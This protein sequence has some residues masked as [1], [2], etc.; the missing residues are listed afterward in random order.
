MLLYDRKRAFLARWVYLGAFITI[1]FVVLTRIET[2]TEVVHKREALPQG[3]IMRFVEESLTGDVMLFYLPVLCTLPY[4]SSFVDELKSGITRFSLTRVSRKKYL[5]SKVWAASLSG[6][7]ILV[8]GALA[9]MAAFT[10]F[11]L[12]LE[13]K[14]YTSVLVGKL[15]GN[16]MQ[17]AL[18]YFCL[19]A[20]DSTAGLLISTLVNNRYMSFM[21]PFMAEYLLIIFHERYFSWCRVLYPKEWLNPSG[22]WPGDSWGVLLWLLCITIFLAWEFVKAGKRRLDRA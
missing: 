12:P 10:V 17:L 6:G 22:N 8:M 16:Y 21:A 19:G 14:K 11:F 15:I 18:R 1:I 3:W 4:A 20:L 2:V 5:C 13:E 7:C 9:V